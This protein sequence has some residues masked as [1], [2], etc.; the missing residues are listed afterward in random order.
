MRRVPWVLILLS[1]NLLCKPAHGQAR[2]GAGKDLVVQAL[3]RVQADSGT[4]R[5][6]DANQLLKRAIELCS[7]LGEAWYYRS[8][9]EGKLGHAQLASYALRQ[10]HYFRPTRCPTGSTRLSCR[11][12]VRAVWRR[13]LHP[14][15]HRNLPAEQR[16]NGRSS[17]ASP[18]SKTK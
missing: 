14:A 8:L 9:V 6:E 7:D 17:L 11:P 10:A 18:R 5:L 12:P 2:C 4:A 3:E 1:S 16:R 13:R 15:S